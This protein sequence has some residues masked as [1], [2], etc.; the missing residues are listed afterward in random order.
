MAVNISV[1]TP[2]IRPEGL[3]L[4][5]KCLKKQTF[6]SYEWLIGSPF[7]PKVDF[8]HRWVQ[9]DFTGGVW[10]LNR[11]YNKLIREAKG[12]LI[13]SIQDF[14]WF[15]YDTLEAFWFWYKEKGDKWCTTGSGHIYDQLDKYLKPYNMIW[16]D[17]RRQGMRKHGSNY[18]CMHEDCEAN[19]CAWPKQMFYDVGGWDEQL[20]FTGYGMDNLSVSERAND[21][22]YRFWIDHTIECKGFRHERPKDWDNKHNMHGAYNKR[23]DELKGVWPKLSYL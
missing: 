11:I 17:P 12:E 8:K 6:L 7:K 3:A 22:G 10:T 16:E 18:E 23:K 20:D 14:I 13:V 9:D 21:L 19:F 4:L 1:I 15:P 2:T 5:D